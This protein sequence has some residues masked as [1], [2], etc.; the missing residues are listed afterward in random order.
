MK[1]KKGCLTNHCGQ[2][3]GNCTDTNW[4]YNAASGLQPLV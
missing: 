4:R 3:G 2:I 1:T